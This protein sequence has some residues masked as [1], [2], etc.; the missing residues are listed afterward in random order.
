MKRIGQNKKNE[1]TINL[2]IQDPI[3]NVATGDLTAN[4]T[5]IYE[6]LSSK[7]KIVKTLARI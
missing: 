6:K 2:T 5:T 3:E 4:D 7:L 1:E